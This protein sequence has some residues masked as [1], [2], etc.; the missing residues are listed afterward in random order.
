MYAPQ[1]LP[2]VYFSV[3]ASSVIIMA[4]MSGLLPPCVVPAFGLR[5]HI[6]ELLSDALFFRRRLWGPLLSVDLSLPCGQITVVLLHKERGVVIQPLECLYIG[7]AVRFQDT[8]QP[9]HTAVDLQQGAGNQRGHI[10]EL[11]GQAPAPR[12]N[13]KRQNILKR[14]TFKCPFF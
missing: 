3:L 4:A 9:V 14:G 6:P 12:L 2:A 5:L 1:G 11:R 7:I 8:G 10:T 13:P